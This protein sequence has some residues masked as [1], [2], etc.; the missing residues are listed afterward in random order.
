MEDPRCNGLSLASFLIMPVQRIPRYSLLLQ[1]MVKHTWTSHPDFQD[2]KEAAQK[3]KECAVAL[4]LKKEESENLEKLAEIESALSSKLKVPLCEPHRRYIDDEEFG[5]KRVWLCNDL[6]LVGKADIS[7]FQKFRKRSTDRPEKWKARRLVWVRDVELVQSP[8]GFVIRKEG[9][10]S[11]LSAITCPATVA[12][13]WCNM[14]ATQKE[15]L[16]NSQQTRA[17]GKRLPLHY[18]CV[19]ERETVY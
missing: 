9:V 10:N 13:K 7:T 18:I 19:R 16:H 15:A 5:D 4:N 14:F 8:E 6:V 2:L 11:V 3:L 12:S 17:L 1:D